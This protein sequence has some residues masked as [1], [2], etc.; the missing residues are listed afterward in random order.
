MCVSTMTQSKAEP[1][2]TGRKEERGWNWG[3]Q[4][5]VLGSA[6]SCLCVLLLVMQTATCL[7]AA[8]N[9]MDTYKLDETEKYNVAMRLLWVQIRYTV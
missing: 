8:Q 7:C 1:M 6:N 3:S 5:V 4:G 2:S 9:C